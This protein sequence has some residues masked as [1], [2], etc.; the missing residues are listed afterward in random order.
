MIKLK[1]I[2]LELFWLFVV[3]IK[4]YAKSPKGDLTVIYYPAQCVEIC[5]S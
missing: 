5:W 3:L 1:Q 4:L 2:K